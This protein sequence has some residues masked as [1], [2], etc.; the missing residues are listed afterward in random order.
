[1]FVDDNKIDNINNNNNNGNCDNN[2]LCI[3][4]NIEA[5]QQICCQQQTNDSN[6]YSPLS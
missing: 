6:D 2:V 5:Y 4:I 1:M 3:C